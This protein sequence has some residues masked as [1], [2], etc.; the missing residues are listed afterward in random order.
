MEKFSN[1]NEF[2]VEIQMLESMAL[3]KAKPCQNKLF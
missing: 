2:M 1:V 3:H